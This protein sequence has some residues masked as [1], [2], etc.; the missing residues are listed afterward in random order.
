MTARRIDRELVRIVGSTTCA[1]AVFDSRSSKLKV[2]A[3]FYANRR[4]SFMTAVPIDCLSS[5][6]D[7]I[8]ARRMRPASAVYR[9]ETC[10]LRSQRAGSV[11]V[12][13]PATNNELDAWQRTDR[14]RHAAKPTSGP[15]MKSRRLP[16]RSGGQ[17]VAHMP[18]I[19]ATYGRI[20][21]MPTRPIPPWVRFFGSVGSLNA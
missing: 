6:V 17:D 8:G 12:S 18:I 9:V 15:A 1:G 21:S 11:N 2:W 16:V 7:S 14:N 5:C 19:V 10:R 13:R 3:R 20:A 4:M